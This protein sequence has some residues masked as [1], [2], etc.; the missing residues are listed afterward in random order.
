MA[1][2]TEYVQIKTEQTPVTRRQNEFEWNMKLHWQKISKPFTLQLNRQ[3]YNPLEARYA[4][5]NRTNEFQS[6]KLLS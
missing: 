2:L 5:L 1:L 4:V 6:L 3:V